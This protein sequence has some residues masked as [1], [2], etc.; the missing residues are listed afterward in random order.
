MKKLISDN[1][2][3]ELLETKYLQYNKLSFIADDPISIPHQFNKREDIEIAAFL[4]ATIAWG[5][6]KTIITNATKLMQ[7]MDYVPYD[8]IMNAEK[9]DLKIFKSFVHRTFNG[10]DCL[11]F[12]E[13]IK[14]IYNNHKGLEQCFIDGFNNGTNIADAITYFR[15]IFF[16]SIINI[17]TMK[18]ISDPS[19]NSAAKRMN[20]FLRWMVRKDNNKVDFGIWHKIK[21]NQLFCPLDIHTGN[22]SRKLGLLNRNANDWKAVAELTENLRKFDINDPVKYD[23]ALFG[24]GIYENF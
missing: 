12:I 19:T 2:I 11:Y 6:R 15:K 9:S 17:R 10:I 1:E 22:V 21:P 16:E 18:H 3:Y 4:T 5:Q 23:F 13:S 24:L 14:N 8:F 20:M 7:W